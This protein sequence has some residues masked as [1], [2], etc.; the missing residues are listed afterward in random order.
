MCVM[1]FQRKR[2]KKHNLF[3]MNCCLIFLPRFTFFSLL[4]AYTS[5]SLARRTHAYTYR[6]TIPPHTEENSRKEKH[7]KNEVHKRNKILCI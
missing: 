3:Y 1:Q 4:I 2:T 5:I 7:N 6:K